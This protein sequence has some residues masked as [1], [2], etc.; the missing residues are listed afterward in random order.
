MDNKVVM[1]ALAALRQIYEHAS[2]IGALST[3]IN[4]FTDQVEPVS[5]SLLRGL[6]DIIVESNVKAFN[7]VV[8]E[9]DKG[10]H[11]ATAV[12]LRADV[13]LTLARIYQYA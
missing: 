12:S 7:V 4:S 11:I 3:T 9:E 13:P 6:A 2:L 10:T 1:S 8:G 5:P